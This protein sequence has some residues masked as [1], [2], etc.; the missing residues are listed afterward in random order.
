[1]VFVSIEIPGLIVLAMLIPFMYVPLAVEGFIFSS[2]EINSMAFS[3][4]FSGVNETRPI[5]E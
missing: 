4:N 1:M 3:A 5:G 2:V